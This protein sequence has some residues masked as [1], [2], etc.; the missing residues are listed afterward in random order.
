MAR[1]HCSEKL[2]RQHIDIMG[3]KEWRDA[4]YEYVNLDDA[5]MDPLRDKQGRLQVTAGMHMPAC[6]E[7]SARA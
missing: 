1:R 3:T 7:R 6:K 2:V 5:W 4:G